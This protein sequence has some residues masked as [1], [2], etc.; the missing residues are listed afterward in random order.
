MAQ[1][2]DMTK[3]FLT[4]FGERMPYVESFPLAQRLGPEERL[5]LRSLFDLE[6]G[7]EPSIIS[8]PYVSP[9]G[10]QGNN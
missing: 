2:S 3:L 5:V 9:D 1:R 10:K 6:A 4:P 8:M 7:E